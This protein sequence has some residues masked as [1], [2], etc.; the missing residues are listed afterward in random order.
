MPSSNEEIINIIAAEINDGYH[1]GDLGK[2]ICYI[3]DNYLL[4]VDPNLI[5][6]P[7]INT[8]VEDIEITDEFC[9]DFMLSKIKFEICSI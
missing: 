7:D 5:Y 2:Y 3:K 6:I 8:M 9:E 1:P 4:Y